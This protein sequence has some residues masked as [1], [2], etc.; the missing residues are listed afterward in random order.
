MADHGS[1]NILV[2]RLSHLGDC[3]Q[4]VPMLNALRDLFPSARITWIVE[5]L[6]ARVLQGLPSLD[7]LII[8]P[9][10]ALSAPGAVWRWRDRLRSA[11]FDI[12]IDPQGLTKSAILGWLAGAPTR[13]GFARADGRELSSWLNNVL[14][15]RTADNV[16]DRYLELLQPLGFTSRAARFGLHVTQQD[17]NWADEFVTHGIPSAHRPLAF[18]AK[19]TPSMSDRLATGPALLQLVETVSARQSTGGFAVL[20]TGA[21]WPSRMWE[22]D[23]F[24]K[25]AQFLALDWNLASV[26][27]WAGPAERAAAE[28]IVNQSGGAAILAPPTSLAEL[29]ALLQRAWLYVGTDSGP[30]HLAVA[31]GTKCVSLHGT[32]LAA[33]SGPYGAGH[34]A[35]QA[36]YQQGSSFRRR[37]AANEAMRAISVEMVC[38][39]CDYVLRELDEVPSARRESN[40]NMQDAGGEM[41]DAGIKMQDAAFRM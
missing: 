35:V 1:P 9:K 4:T 11:A 7:E 18:D 20:N 31:M 28:R 16:V 29:A 38:A 6:G 41:S 37:R 30:L 15:R 17:R 34:A 33:K 23:R 21:G 36:Y 12:A 40:S 22:T 5:P 10:R 19:R 13:I 39:A 24:A 2:T 14:V 32:T 27:A 26:I 3:I 8:I 25:V